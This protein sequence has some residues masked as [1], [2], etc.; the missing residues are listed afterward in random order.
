MNTTEQLLPTSILIQ[1]QSRTFRKE[2]RN[3]NVLVA[4]VRYDDDCKNG[5]NTFAITGELYD[6][7]RANGEP[8][9][10]NSKGVKRWMGSCGCLHDE[11]AAAFPE[12]AP[13]IKWHLVSS[14]SPMHY[15]AN[16]IYHAS[17]RKFNYAR[18][19]AIWPEA[20]D[21]Q[22][23]ASPEEL[24]AALLERLPALMAEFKAAV[25]SLGF[26]Y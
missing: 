5:H 25:E 13:L 14:D 21:E 22:L 7:G 12:L 17:N 10:L 16:T 23:C 19:S 26:T 20:T 6:Q 8:S 2:F 3:G 1:S 18:S 15:V 4:K 9:T 11:I 24:K